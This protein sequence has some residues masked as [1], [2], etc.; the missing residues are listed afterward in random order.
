MIASAATITTHHHRQNPSTGNTQVICTCHGK[1]FCINRWISD[2]KWIEIIW[3][4]YID[5][6]SKEKEE[7]LNFNRG[8]MLRAVGSIR[9]EKEAYNN[10]RRL[11]TN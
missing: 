2:D 8:N 5:N 10:P 7:E 11:H 6:P 4:N 9:W 3:N 1:K